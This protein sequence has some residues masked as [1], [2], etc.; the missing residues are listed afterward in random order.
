MYVQ[1][2]FI[3]ILID[4]LTWQKAHGCDIGNTIFAAPMYRASIPREINID[5]LSKSEL[6][7]AVFTAYLVRNI[8]QQSTD[9]P[10]LWQY[11]RSSLTIWD[12]TILV[13]LSVR[14]T[15]VWAIYLQTLCKMSAY[16]AII[17]FIILDVAILFLEHKSSKCT[18]SKRSQN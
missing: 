14:F 5:H 6:Q 2:Q 13:V 7:E 1:K 10:P 3:Y 11:S 18:R 8:P 9:S 17:F 16:I 15:Y 4:K 12:I